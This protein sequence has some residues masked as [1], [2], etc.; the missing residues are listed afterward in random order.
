MDA[1]N[2]GVAEGDGATFGFW[3][4]TDR[5]F[6]RD[7]SFVHSRVYWARGNGWAI[8]A[9]IAAIE[10]SS[11]T[12]PHRAEYIAVFKQHAAKLLET[13]DSDGSGGFWHA[14]LLNGSGYPV[15]ETTGTASFAY[16]LAWGVNNGLLPAKN[17]LPALHT[18]WSW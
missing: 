2:N 8:S 11:P 18:T 3:N 16:A 1:K 7:D 5:L 4:A 9:L 15:P 13:Q 17:Y 12:A 14:S 6:Y 10:H